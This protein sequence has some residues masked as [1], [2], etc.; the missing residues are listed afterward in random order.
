M[1]NE[2][3]CEYYEFYSPWS[4]PGLAWTIRKAV[5]WYKRIIRHDVDD[6][7]V[8]RMIHSIKIYIIFSVSLREKILWSFPYIFT[9]S[10]L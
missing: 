7:D 10:T 4:S 8:L 9:S 5:A 6:D 1:S 2:R 3:N